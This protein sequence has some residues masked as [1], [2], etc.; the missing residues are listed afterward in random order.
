MN[1][2][3]AFYGRERLVYDTF[4]NKYFNFRSAD[5][6]NRIKVIPPDITLPQ[7]S[8]VHILDNLYNEERGYANSDV[9]N[10]DLPFIRNENYRKFVYH[11]RQ[12]NTKERGLP[13][14]IPY[15]YI[16]RTIG[17]DINLKKFRMTYNNILPIT[18][19]SSV[20]STPTT[21]TIVNHNPLFRV[22][23]RELLPQYKRFMII[24]GSILNTAARVQGK[25]QYIFFPLG[26]RVFLRS[27]FE[28]AIKEIRPATL[29]VK[30]SF[31]YFL[32]LH[33]LNFINPNATESIFRLYPK[34]LYSSTIFVFYHENN[35]MFYNLAEALKL[36][37]NNAAYTRFIN[38]YN[39]LVLT[40]GDVGIPEDSTEQDIQDAADASSIPVEGTV[41]KHEQAQAEAEKVLDDAEN[42]RA[43]SRIQGFI[44]DITGLTKNIS[45]LLRLPSKDNT[46]PPVKYRRLREVNA[47]LDPDAD[48]DTLT[49]DDE[50]ALQEGR[51]EEKQKETYPQDVEDDTTEPLEEVATLESTST[52]ADIPVSITMSPNPELQSTPDSPVSVQ[53]LQE[54]VKQDTYITGK[55]TSVTASTNP[56]DLVDWGKSYM[57]E[58]DRAAART[59]LGANPSL[60]RMK[61][62]EKIGVAY[63]SVTINNRTIEDILT[64]P[65]DITVDKHG[66]EADGLDGY[67]ADPTMKTSSMRSFDMD[68]MEKLYDRDMAEVAISFNKEGMFLVGLDKT[69]YT[70]ELNRLVTYKLHYEDIDGK[71]FTIPVTL[72]DVDDEGYC[73]VNGTKQYFRTQI[74]N[75]PICK[76]SEYRVNLISYYN[77]TTVER[78]I[79]RSH[80]YLPY[81]QRIFTKIR[82]AYPGALTTMYGIT[83]NV[84]G[85]AGLPYEYAEICK[86]YNTVK[87]VDEK[88]SSTYN[89]NFDLTNRFADVD[90]KV[91]TR[92][93]KIEGMLHGVYAG[94]KDHSG[95]IEH[96]FFMHNSSIKI[97]DSNDDVVLQTTFIDL[98][99]SIFKLTLP[100]RL[101]EFAHIQMV[102]MFFPVGFVLCYKHGLKYM[103]EYLGVDY[104]LVDKQE[105]RSFKAIRPTDTILTFKNKYLII[106]RYPLRNS[107]IMT[108]L[109]KYD[110]AK[111]DIEEFGMSET[112]EYNKNDVYY[113]LLLD[114]GT[115]VSYL[116]NITDTFS[117]FVDPIT[118]KQLIQMNEPTNFT[119]LLIRAV[120]LVS[121]VH[122]L[123][124][125][126]MA[127]HRYRS[128]ERFNGIM[129]NAMARAH[130]KFTR[131]KGAG[132]KFSLN[133]N[134]IFLRVIG[135]QSMIQVE[136]INP[137]QAIKTKTGITY[138]GSGGR[139]GESF[140][141]NDRRFPK[142]GVGML[143]E[144]TPDSGNVAIS[145]YTPVDPTIANLYGISSHKPLEDITPS[146]A[147][148]V[149][150][151]LMPGVTQ[152]D[153]K[154]T[155]FVGIQLTHHMPSTGGEC[156]RYRTG[157]EAM[158]AHRT[159]KLYAV[160]AKQDGKVVSVDT[161]ARMYKVEYADGSTAAYAFG[162]EYGSCPD[163]VTT[164]KQELTVKEGDT[165]KKGEILS[166]NPEFFERDLTKREVYWKHGVVTT[167]AL[168]E[169]PGTYEDSS[170]VT[171]N[172][173]DKVAI[174]PVNVRMITVDRNTYVHDFKRIGSHVEIS[175]PLM[176]FEP[177]DTTD[178]SS[179]AKDDELLDYL[180]RLNRKL[181]KSKHAGT[182]VAMEAYAGCPY[183]EL[184]PTLKQ[185]FNEA[186]RLKRNRH[187][188]AKGTRQADNNPEPT[189]IPKGVKFKNV[190]FDE[191]TVVIRYLI[192]E[193]KHVESG[194]KIVVASN[195]KSVI[196]GV[197]PES[198]VTESGVPVD[199]LFSVS[200]C[201]NRI[202]GSVVLQGTSER[203]LKEAERQILDIWKK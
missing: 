6:S 69:K 36:N 45:K 159:D 153:A 78:N 163:L 63:K 197:L 156:L 155:G 75:L 129:Y 91:K 174:E 62:L 110:L 113:Q 171:K 146:N 154:R 54:V 68:Y 112:G 143:S 137:V 34:E 49:F 72:P 198:P 82:A 67:L 10:M 169:I 178:L 26:D 97:V 148:S 13:V 183:S 81:I 157:F 170:I 38:Q 187:H 99:L 130:D 199:L 71:R 66:S 12:P 125:S 21:L 192:K 33:W 141:V 14:Q 135:D 28:Q 58:V 122:H 17:L 133:P 128:F 189:P 4:H 84:S 73:F 88:G 109:S 185:V 106:P 152:D 139:S 5:V 85:Y 90:S 47:N 61:R 167:T 96:M 132:N 119:D 39:S 7:N 35:Y 144:L 30:N 43:V 173:S 57:D 1:L 51:E 196:G 120:D 124:A 101:Q 29:R 95:A 166:Y 202:V 165:F 107:L 70:N 201:M 188:F 147:L 131:R 65:V 115:S 123:E 25:K 121:T 168:L 200:S 11:N 184:H 80:S 111:Y 64:T 94:T 179:M 160:E 136:D 15:N 8:I 138:T 31:H 134:D 175:D 46:V 19:I 186:N 102:D 93:E 117:K 77:K 83:D 118:R 18:K 79:N 89:F 191:N 56:N 203:V 105:R 195:L 194:D 20:P 44:D 140:V 9:P 114:K 180:S 172:F 87:I 40:T 74:A 158:I 16:F 3:Q 151:V 22:R 177:A 149:S 100:S 162:E 27:M 48:D 98:L 41:D 190:L 176:V 37:V 142:D 42:K 104:K 164:Q 52:D 127:N 103:L 53:P 23:V 50:A 86:V 59:M 108:G 24:I 92:L 55:L 32:M 60:S 150:A 116:K 126:A 76:V 182:I 161:D 193:T 2:T 145:A 181:P